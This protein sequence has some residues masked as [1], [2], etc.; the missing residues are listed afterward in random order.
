MSASDLS[1]LPDRHEATH[2]HGASCS[3]APAGTDRTVRRLQVLT[4][5]WML[6][7]CS[8]ALTASWRA[9]SPAL[10]AFGADSSVEL[11]SAVVVL[12]QFT[13]IFKISTERATR[14]AGILLYLLAGIVAVI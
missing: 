1:P 14:I 10:L 9:H 2:T 4:I 12:L 11:L 7:E 6:V 5:C 13:S 8:M 3:H